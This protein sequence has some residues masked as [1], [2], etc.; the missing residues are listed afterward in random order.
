MCIWANASYANGGF[1]ETTASIYGLSSVGLND[2]TSSARNYTDH[3]MRLS[4]DA[5]YTGKSLCFYPNTSLANLGTYGLNDTISSIQNTSG[6]D[7]GDTI[8]K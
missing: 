3:Y 2:Q 1:D 4:Q 6:C 5:G 8:I 7:N